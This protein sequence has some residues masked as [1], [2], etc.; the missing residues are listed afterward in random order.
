MLYEVITDDSA[1]IVLDRCIPETILLTPENRSRL[2]E[3][4]K[5]WVLKYAAYDGG[6]QA[7]YNF[8]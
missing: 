5:A 4:H 1:L 2:L 8:V 3:G 7:S 6:N